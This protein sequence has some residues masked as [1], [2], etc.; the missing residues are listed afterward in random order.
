LEVDETPPLFGGRRSL[1][2]NLMILITVKN[3]IKIVV[4]FA[5]SSF[6]QRSNSEDPVIWLIRGDAKVC[7]LLAPEERSGQRY[8]QAAKFATMEAVTKN[9]TY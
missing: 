7:Q 2:V 6:R 4:Q 5:W 3:W 1:P 9:Y 8:Q